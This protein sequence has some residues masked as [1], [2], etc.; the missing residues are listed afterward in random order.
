MKEKQR[1]EMKREEEKNANQTPD[2]DAK[3][4]KLRTNSAARAS[5]A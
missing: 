5:A 1:K 3:T 4:N 2:T